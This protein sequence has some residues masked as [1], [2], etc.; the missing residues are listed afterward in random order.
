ME[1]CNI[2]LGNGWTIESAKNASLGKGMKIEIFAQFEVLNDD[3]TWI[4]DI[5]LPSD[6]AISECKKIA[7]FNKTCKFVVYD[8]D[9]NGDNWIKKESFSGTF[10][11]ALEYI[12][13]NFKV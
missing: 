8:L 4:Y 10:I 12:K 2:C 9:K 3:I 7:M 1:I 13:E 11:D 5:V 6:E